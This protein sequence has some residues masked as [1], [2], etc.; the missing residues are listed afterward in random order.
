MPHPS[1]SHAGPALDLVKQSGLKSHTLFATFANEA[2]GTV[3]YGFDGSVYSFQET[4]EQALEM[5]DIVLRNPVSRDLL[6]KE[7][8][9]ISEG[10]TNKKGKAGSP[11]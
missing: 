8:Q 11:F 1:T 10:G 4:R 6:L 9:T 3:E 2:T 5:F 7:L